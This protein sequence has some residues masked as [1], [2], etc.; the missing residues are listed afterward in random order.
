MSLY[1]FTDAGRLPFI[2]QSCVL[3]PSRNQIG[4]FPAPDFL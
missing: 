2:L 3:N 4:G 1:D